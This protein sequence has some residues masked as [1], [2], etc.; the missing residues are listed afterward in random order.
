MGVWGHSGFYLD[1]GNF[2]EFDLGPFLGIFGAKQWTQFSK[3]T[4]APP[5]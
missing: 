4:S 1:L 2:L 3:Y 5:K